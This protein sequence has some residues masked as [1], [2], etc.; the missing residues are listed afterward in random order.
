MRFRLRFMLAI[1]SGPAMSQQQSANTNSQG[2]SAVAGN[3]ISDSG[4]A[5]ARVD[6][7][8]ENPEATKGFVYFPTVTCKNATSA[9]MVENFL[10]DLSNTLAEFTHIEVKYDGPVA[11]DSPKLKKYPVIC[12]SLPAELTPGEERGLQDYLTSG[13]FVLFSPPLNTIAMI[14]DFLSK[15]ARIEESVPESHPVYNALYENANGG[16]KAPGAFVRMD[17]VLIGDRLVGTSFTG[18]TAHMSASADNERY[19]KALIN[20]VVYA[21]NRQ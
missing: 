1:Q 12:I 11:L 8:L 16:I 10:R 4:G 2:T 14:R 20:I 9:G 13:G 21:L 19:K 18:F 6:V 5:R 15:F 17:G 7:N 3:K